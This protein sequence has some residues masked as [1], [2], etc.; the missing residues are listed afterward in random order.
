MRSKLH[1][2]PNLIRSCKSHAK[3]FFPI[4]HCSK[5]GRRVI[6]AVMSI[7]IQLEDFQSWSEV[8]AEIER[9]RNMRL[10]GII[11]PNPSAI[12]YGEKNRGSF[13]A[14]NEGRRFSK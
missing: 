4:N 3:A 12:R 8:F 5:V 2:I 14:V 6:I 13:L 10:F 9:Q 7:T 11:Q 1:N